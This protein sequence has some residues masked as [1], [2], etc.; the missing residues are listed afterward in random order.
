LLQTPCPNRELLSQIIDSVSKYGENLGIVHWA[1]GTNHNVN[2]VLSLL[3]MIMIND[4]R[5]NIEEAEIKT[6]SEAL[7]EADKYKWIESEKAG[8]DLGESVVVEWFRKNWEAYYE[9]I[10]KNLLDQNQT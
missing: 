10:K 7:D 9:K 2:E 3:R 1:T 5:L 8:R 6:L 4:K